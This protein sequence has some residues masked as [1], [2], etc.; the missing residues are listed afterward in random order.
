M[1]EI[2]SLNIKT[3]IEW[4]GQMVITT[5]QLAEA[6][7][8]SPDNVKRNF[9]RN[10]D[11]FVSG[12]HYYLLE[13]EELQ[14]FK[15]LGTES[16]VVGKS[17]SQLYL[18]TRRGASRHCKIL[19][20]DR[21]WEQFDYLEENYFERESVP[22]LPQNPM[23]LL[24]LHYQAIKQVDNKVNT[25]E[26]R[27]DNFE[28]SLPLLPN[29]ADEVSRAVKK[30][31][32]EVLGGKDAPAYK[33]RGICQKTFKDAYRELKRN[34]N[35]SRYKDIKREQKEEAVEIAGKYEPP[36]FLHEQIDQANAQITMDTVA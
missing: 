17:A 32:V 23:E 6:Y 33:N 30:R 24:E 28:K 7:G 3:P 36:L 31:V 13:G 34:F 21:A 26:H 4:N 16:P 22:Q 18:W 19:G 5:V 25:L 1:Q 12:K 8:T 11:K 14:R 2:T 20:T 15:S 9:N 10:K 35:V 29:E 27:F